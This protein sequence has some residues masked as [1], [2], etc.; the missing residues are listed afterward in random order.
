MSHCDRN[1]PHLNVRWPYMLLIP[2]LKPSLLFQLV[3]D[4]PFS[5][6]SI[7]L[8]IVY[9]SRYNTCCCCPLLQCY[10]VDYAIFRLCF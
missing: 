1:V 7:G 2:H 3:L 9:V 5:F 8:D 10:P 6:F 4:V